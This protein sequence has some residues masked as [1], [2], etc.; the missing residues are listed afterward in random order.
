[1]ELARKSLYELKYSCP[2]VNE[3]RLDAHHLPLARHLPVRDLSDAINVRDV[4][5]VVDVLESGGLHGLLKVVKIGKDTVRVHRQQDMPDPGV[6]LWQ[7]RSLVRRSQCGRW[8]F[9]PR[10]THPQPSIPLA[11]PSPSHLVVLKPPLETV[12]Q[13]CLVEV[14][15]P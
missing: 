12:Q 9:L 10:D 15:E 3:L 11:T 13:G 4:E 5:G 14:V 1:M 8:F 2:P 7:Y 6:D